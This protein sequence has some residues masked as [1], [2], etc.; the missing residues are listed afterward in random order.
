MREVWR[1]GRSDGAE[2]LGAVQ[3]PK[4]CQ[5]VAAGRAAARQSKAGAVAATAAEA[6]AR[7][8]GVLIVAASASVAMWVDGASVAMGA[9]SEL[10]TASAVGTASGMSSA[11]GTAEAGT[12]VSWARAACSS[13]CAVAARP[14]RLSWSDLRMAFR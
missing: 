7:G 10:K 12:D 1:R 14:D 9:A 6:R 4:R 11:S 5:A 13:A 8:G 2:R 3:R